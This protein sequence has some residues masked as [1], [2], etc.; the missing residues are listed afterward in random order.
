MSWYELLLNRCSL[1]HTWPAGNRCGFKAARFKAWLLKFLWL[2]F[3]FKL[4][5]WGVCELDDTTV[6]NHHRS[7]KDP[8]EDSAENCSNVCDIFPASILLLFTFLWAT[9]CV[10]LSDGAEMAIWIHVMH[11]I[12]K[13]RQQRIWSFFSVRTN[14]LSWNTGGAGDLGCEPENKAS[15]KKKKCG[16]F[17]PQQERY[18]TWDI[19][20][21]H[22][23]CLFLHWKKSCVIIFLLHVSNK[24]CLLF[25]LRC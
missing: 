4:Y 13:G 3:V 23:M 10:G 15:T 7:F 20:L 18:L 2:W 22:S 25:Y 6:I 12:D 17:K 11:M 5:T 24:M 21:R 8:Q 14:E 19:S 16:K 9:S 1:L